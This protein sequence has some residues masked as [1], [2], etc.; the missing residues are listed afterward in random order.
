MQN[1][2][3]KK[4][5]SINDLFIPAVSDSYVLILNN[6]YS[7]AMKKVNVALTH[8]WKQKRRSHIPDQG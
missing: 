5:R 1:V 4:G 7:D 3:Q 8:S 6:R 2:Y